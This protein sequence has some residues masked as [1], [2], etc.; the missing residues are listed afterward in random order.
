MDQNTSKKTFSAKKILLLVFLCFGVLCV[1]LLLGALVLQNIS[2]HERFYS[3][4]SWLVTVALSFWIA[5]ISKRAGG[6]SV[7]LSTLISGIFSIA[8]I[9]IGCLLA[10]KEFN[11]VSILIRFFSL[12]LLSI[13]AAVLL[14]YIESKRKKAIKWKKSNNIKR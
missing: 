2:K 13:G 8:C 1:L 3:S 7:L 5:M 10:T 11:I 14:N 4:I 12:I 6:N 9:A